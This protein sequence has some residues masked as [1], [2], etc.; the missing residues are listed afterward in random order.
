ME[1][2]FKNHLVVHTGEKPF[3][4]EHCPKAFPFKNKLKRHV[5]SLHSERKYKCSTCGMAY[6]TREGLNQHLRKHKVG[7]VN[8]HWSSRCREVLPNPNPFLPFQAQT[9]R[10]PAVQEDFSNEKQSG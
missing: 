5:L 8:D 3:Q 4:C 1:F 9:I 2:N 6:G 7:M 10:M